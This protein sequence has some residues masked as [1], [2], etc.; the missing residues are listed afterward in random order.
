MVTLL[1]VSMIAF[2]GVP[3]GK[4]KAKEIDRATGA[5]IIRGD[6]PYLGP[7]HANEGRRTLAAATFDITFVHKQDKIDEIIIKEV[8]F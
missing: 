4:R 2:G 7:T 1:F 8:R 6:C 5:S 3:I